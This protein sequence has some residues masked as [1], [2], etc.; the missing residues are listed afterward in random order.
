VKDQLEL[1][2]RLGI[3]IGPQVCQKISRLREADAAE[4]VIDPVAEF[5]AGPGDG[6]IPGVDGQS[7]CVQ[8]TVNFKARPA[9]GMASSVSSHHFRPAAMVDFTLAISL[10]VQSSVLVSNGP[11]WNPIPSARR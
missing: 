11:C 10:G 4:K 5:L 3:V 1:C 6:L 2:A 8:S 9:L 7:A